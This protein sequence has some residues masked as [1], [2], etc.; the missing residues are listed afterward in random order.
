MT[1]LKKHVSFLVTTDDKTT[2]SLEEV[3][4]KLSTLTRKLNAAKL[5][6]REL[7]KQAIKSIINRD[8][9]KQL[10]EN[11]KLARICFAALF[12]PNINTAEYLDLIS[13]ILESRAYFGTDVEFLKNAAFVYKAGF[14]ESRASH[15]KL[16]SKNYPIFRS[17]PIV[18]NTS[19]L[20]SV[21]REQEKFTQIFNSLKKNADDRLALITAE[22]ILKQQ[23]KKELA[24]MIIA[25]DEWYPTAKCFPKKG[26]HP[27][28]H[29]PKLQ[30][31]LEADND[32]F[33]SE[34]KF[35]GEEFEDVIDTVMEN[36]NDHIQ[37]DEPE[38]DYCGVETDND[39]FVE[40]KSEPEFVYSGVENDNDHF[41]HKPEPV[42]LPVLPIQ[43]EGLV[44]NLP[45]GEKLVVIR[46]HDG[47]MKYLVIGRDIDVERL[48]KIYS[49]L[50]REELK[51]GDNITT[52]RL[53]RIIKL[54]ELL[55]AG[56]TQS[57]AAKYLEV[58]RYIVYNDTR[59][60]R[61]IEVLNNAQ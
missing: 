19:V 36:D 44:Q 15:M 58:P 23:E 26:Y 7:A 20:D 11:T 24:E 56:F 51:L 46:K 4:G 14:E 31:V 32:H 59:V 53:T 40:F 35:W 27:Y 41:I 42:E 12:T 22:E 17:G 61:S 34:R 28:T 33:M 13:Q 1:N 21:P 60:L 57:E 38:I 6:R 50:V 47:N 39:H 18:I 10:Q 3:L 25:D 49:M 16:F 8:P 29:E 43:H 37:E 45:N 54:Q 30:I 48:P 5:Q 52:D 2:E 55:E 9:F